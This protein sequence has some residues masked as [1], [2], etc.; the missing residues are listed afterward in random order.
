MTGS[1][2]VAPSL[3]S[4]RAGDVCFKRDLSDSALLD[5]EPAQR[6]QRQGGQRREQ[7][8][9]NWGQEAGSANDEQLLSRDELVEWGEATYGR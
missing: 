1:M 3:P 5:L 7:G 8:E 2:T 4:A 9:L 6:G